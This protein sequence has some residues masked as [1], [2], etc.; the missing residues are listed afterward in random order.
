MNL[1]NTVVSG[2]FAFEVFLLLYSCSTCYSAVDPSRNAAF[3]ISTSAL[4]IM[5]HLLG[6]S[7]L[8][9]VATL[10]PVFFLH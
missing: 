6:H 5:L 1:V 3:G 9:L 7:L 8:M 4:H 2:V 10:P